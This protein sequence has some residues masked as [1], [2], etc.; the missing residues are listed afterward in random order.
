MNFFP[1][2]IAAP[3]FANV[4]QKCKLLLPTSLH[5]VLATGKADP[6][7]TYGTHTDR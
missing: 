1:N 2:N 4:K 3:Y 7:T 5:I 6:L